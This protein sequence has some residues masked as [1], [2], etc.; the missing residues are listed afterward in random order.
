MQPITTS[1]MSAASTPA[2]ESAPLAATAPSSWPERS[3]NIPPKLPTGVRAPSTMTI[4]SSL[5]RR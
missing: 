3:L 2:R 4:F 1:E 5:M